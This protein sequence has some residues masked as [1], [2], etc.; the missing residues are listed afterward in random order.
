MSDK[1]N[2]CGKPKEEPE[3]FRCNKCGIKHRL[4]ERKRG[5]WN[6]W[7]E[8]GRGREPKYKGE[9]ENGSI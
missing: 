1:C 8:T 2:R 5:K 4:H 7:A 6:P 9:E 3:L